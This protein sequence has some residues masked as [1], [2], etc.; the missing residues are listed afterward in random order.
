MYS[1]M[2]TIVKMAEAAMHSSIRTLRSSDSGFGISKPRVPAY[3]P[4]PT[5]SS[6]GLGPSKQLVG[7]PADR[8]KGLRVAG[9]AMIAPHLAG[10]QHPF[11]M[12]AQIHLLGMSSPLRKTA[13]G[14]GILF[15]DPGAC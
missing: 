11:R 3:V 13:Y 4:S 1:T 14:R 2:A 12:R 5:L 8:L 6:R 7:Q 10:R 15:E 9:A